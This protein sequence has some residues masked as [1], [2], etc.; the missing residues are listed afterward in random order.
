MEHTPLLPPQEASP[1]GPNQGVSLGL[2]FF[3]LLLFDTAFTYFLP[4]GSP[5][6]I[7]ALAPLYLLILFFKYG[8]SNVLPSFKVCGL[9]YLFLVSIGLGYFTIPHFVYAGALYNFY[10]WADDKILVIVNAVCVFLIGYAAFNNTEDHD[11]VA[12][13]FLFVG[14]AYGII[15]VI[16]LKQWYPERFP[17][18]VSVYSTGTALVNRPAITTNQNYQVNYLIPAILPL[19]LPFRTL[20]TALCLF[21]TACATFTLLRIQSRSGLLVFG[22][23]GVLCLLI[24]FF[25]KVQGKGKSLFLLACLG[26]AGLVFYGVLREE[27][28]HVMG[29][30]ADKTETTTSG[31][32]VSLM[33]LFE[34]LPDPAW[35][36]PRGTLEFLERHQVEPHCTPTLMFCDAGLSGLVSWLLLICAPAVALMLRVVRGRAGWIAIMVGLAGI[37]SLFLQLSLPAHLSKQVW[38]WAGAVIACLAKTRL[39]SGE[40]AGDEPPPWPVSGPL[41]PDPQPLAEPTPEA[42]PWPKP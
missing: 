4:K 15:C 7:N 40:E 28:A 8:W 37:G 9:L 30:F 19:A 38:L 22:G 29:R 23:I 41:G 6:R 2:V 34:K 39:E 33:Y 16:A 27:S 42:G 12:R 36:I 26:I 14:L 13:V 11:A 1:E 25:S 18:D 10:G 32:I 21:G 20:R 35:W 31:R 24:P 17:L 3:A 5:F